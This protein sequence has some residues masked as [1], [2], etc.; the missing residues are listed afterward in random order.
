PSRAKAATRRDE[1]GVGQS[2]TRQGTLGADDLREGGQPRVRCVQ[3]LRG[4]ARQSTELP[5][6][7]ARKPP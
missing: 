2:E 3:R 5:G 6:E 4:E 1:T 7:L